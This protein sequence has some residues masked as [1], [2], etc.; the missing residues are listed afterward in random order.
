MERQLARPPKEKKRNV[1]AATDRT[2]EKYCASGQTNIELW[3]ARTHARARAGLLNSVSNC[4]CLAFA[5]T[6]KQTRRAPARLLAAGKELLKSTRF[7]EHT[8]KRMAANLRTSH[9]RYKLTQGLAILALSPARPASYENLTGPGARPRLH[10]A[11]FTAFR[12][13]IFAKTRIKVLL[14]VGR[15][16]GVAAPKFCRSVLRRMAV[17]GIHFARL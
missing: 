11:A 9:R 10:Q 5:P 7:T 15:T 1:F 6:R 17:H 12:F 14:P 13:L 8:Q 16:C 2:E 4:R 3:R